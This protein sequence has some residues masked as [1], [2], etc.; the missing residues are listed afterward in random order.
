[1]ENH[2]DTGPGTADPFN[3]D[4]S[5]VQLPELKAA[6]TARI[7][8]DGLLRDPLLLREDLTEGC[9]GQLWPAGI[10]LAK[11]MLREHHS[12]LLGKPMSV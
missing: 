7:S 11:Y 9:G 10:L 8:L 4:E 12:D 2:G 6:S 3:L 5:L 1:M